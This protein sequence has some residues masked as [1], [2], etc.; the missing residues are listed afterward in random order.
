[1]SR[2]DAYLKLVER[3]CLCG[4][5]RIA[6]CPVHA[7]PGDNRGL[8]AFFQAGMPGAFPSAATCSICGADGLMYPDVELDDPKGAPGPAKHRPTLICPSCS[9]PAA[10]RALVREVEAS[11]RHQLNGAR[12]FGARAVAA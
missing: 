1:M 9:S 6:D 11:G 2:M 3:G 7:K 4:T 5:D 12:V 10:E 8:R